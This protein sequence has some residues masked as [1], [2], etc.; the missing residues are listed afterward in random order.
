MYLGKICEVGSPADL[1]ATPAH[2]NTAAL[3]RSI[4][5]P[6]PTVAPVST[7]LLTGDLPSPI[8]PPSG[9]RFRTRCPIAQE[10][11]ALEEPQVRAI[12]DGHFVACHF[13][14]L[15]STAPADDVPVAVSG[16]TS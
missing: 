7:G 8:D 11:C 5:V 9:C 1:Y 10:R 3:R 15:G 13:P 14:I 12:G 16:T 6:D 2:P 4:P